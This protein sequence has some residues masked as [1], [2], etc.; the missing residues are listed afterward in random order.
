MMTI[1]AKKIYDKPRKGKKEKDIAQ[2]K[3]HHKF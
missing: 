2:F 1:I 3:F